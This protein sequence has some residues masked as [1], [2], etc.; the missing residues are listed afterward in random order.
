M[1]TANEDDIFDSIVNRHPRGSPTDFDKMI[2]TSPNSS[3]TSKKS[4]SRPIEP[5]LTVHVYISEEASSIQ[6]RRNK[7]N[8]VESHVIMDGS[9]FAQVS[10]VGAPSNPPFCIRLTDP[11]MYEDDTYQY[12]LKY[13]TLYGDHELN[14]VTVPRGLKERFKIASYHRSITKKYM[15]V[16]IDS[17]VVRKGDICNI[18][19]KIQAKKN[20]HSKGAMENILVAMAVPPTVIGKSLKINSGDGVYD[21]LKRIVKWNV[22]KLEN[23]NS[24]RFE[25]EAKVAKKVIGVKDIP[26]F[27]I[28]LRCSSNEDTV[29]SIEVNIEPMKNQP[30]TLNVIQHR[31]FKILH[32]LP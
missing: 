31:S 15:P 23:G 25:A 2:K 5:K 30:V 8:E 14:V 22:G 13:I 4:F 3:R 27:P 17:N 11:D 10:S 18:V 6:E 26:S 16:E 24:I 32:R 21:D 1:A 20:T 12:D 28:V 29:S 7:F 9:I 19:V